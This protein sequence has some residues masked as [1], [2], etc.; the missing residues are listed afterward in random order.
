MSVLE[1]NS[2]VREIIEEMAEKWPSSIIA[3]DE[4]PSFTGGTISQGRMANLDCLGE[5]PERIRISR[6][7]VYPVKP[8]IEWLIARSEPITKKDMDEKTKLTE[9]VFKKL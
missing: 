8:F 9:E 1:L 3:R 5:G 4:V 6:K 7:V 2:K